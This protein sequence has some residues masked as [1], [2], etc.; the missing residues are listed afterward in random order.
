MTSNDR[1]S[2]PVL[3]ALDDLPVWDVDARRA[4][5]LGVRC[6]AAL[7]AQARATAGADSPGSVRWTHL[8]GLALLTLWCAAYVLEIVRRG[9]A[10]W[11]L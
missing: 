5:D 2:D 11:G 10:V 3:A 9:A 8:A 7:A 1:H 6:R 4:W